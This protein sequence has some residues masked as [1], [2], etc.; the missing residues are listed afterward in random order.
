MKLDK[1]CKELANP[2]C[3]D[4]LISLSEKDISNC[5][6]LLSCQYFNTDKYVLRLF[7]TLVKYIIKKQIVYSLELKAVIYNEVF[8]TRKQKVKLEKGE[9]SKLR[10][11]YSDLTKIILRCLSIEALSENK[12]LEDDL[13]FKSLLQKKQYKLFQR[14]ANNVRKRL[15]NRK[16]RS[17]DY[18]KNCFVIEAN[19]QMLNRFTGQSFQKE[20]LEDLNKH[21]DITYIIDK[22][23]THITLLT[24]QSA[25]VNLYDYSSMD[26]IKSLLNLP[27]YKNDLSIKLY[28]SAVQLIQQPT[29]KNYYQFLGLLSEFPEKL[30]KS[31]TESLYL[32]ASNF[33]TKQIRL[34]NFEYSNLFDLYEL[35]HQNN[36]LIR[37][38]YIN[39]NELKNIVTVCCRTQNYKWAE[40]LIETCFLYLTKTIRVS[41]QNHN[42]G[43]LAFYQNEYEKAHNFFSKVQ[44]INLNYNINNRLML[45]KTFYETDKYFD[46]PT[47]THFESEKRYFDRHKL[48]GSVRSKTY[49]NFFVI[50][51]DLY[52]IKHAVTRKTPKQL[53]LKL[54]K[55]KNVVTKDWLLE[56]MQ[57]LEQHK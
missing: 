52:R 16:D 37:D 17:S 56:K 33:C 50:L 3:V 53:K 10:A 42:F 12:S 15:L 5:S 49:K 14:R 13:V 51:K 23:K 25:S 47:S 30:P 21:L 22:L 35:M 2:L 44:S 36:F 20:K 34:G 41:V 38:D 27:Q 39:E 6:H 19:T 57:E 43:L 32:V 48:L 46:W 28:S 55:M 40:E 9:Y 54:D 1:N 4:L 7:N 11:K 31:E 29:V 24:E 45:S 18:H 8:Q 26:A